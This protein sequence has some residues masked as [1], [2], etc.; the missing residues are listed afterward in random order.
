MRILTSSCKSQY[1]IEGVNYYIRNDSKSFSLMKK[2]SNVPFQSSIEKFCIFEDNEKI[3]VVCI[4]KNMVD[5][6]TY[7][8]PNKIEKILE[9]NIKNFQEWYV[10]LNLFNKK[11][12]F[13]SK[14]EFRFNLPPKVDFEWICKN[15]FKDDKINFN[16]YNAEIFNSICVQTEGKI[17]KYKL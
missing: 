8:G 12:S 15:N 10:N 2:G 1:F 7:N 16:A 6:Y 4:T 17:V 9:F 14:F 11:I 5:I 13:N 3:Y